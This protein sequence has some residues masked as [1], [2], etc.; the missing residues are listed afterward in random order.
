MSDAQALPGLTIVGSSRDGPGQDR[1]DLAPPLPALFSRPAL[2]E[3]GQYPHQGRGEIG[4]IGEVLRVALDEPLAH[5]KA[6]PE[7]PGGRV[8]LAEV[9]QHQADRVPCGRLFS[10]A[11]ADRTGSARVRCR[12]R[13]VDSAGS[14]FVAS[15]ERAVG[16]MEARIRS[17]AL[18]SGR[19]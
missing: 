18:K 17:S 9:E 15:V 10:S 8:E 6:L 5:A 1:G 19:P 14:G 3:P 13:T 16:R 7:A 2:I 11:C 12:G 4:L